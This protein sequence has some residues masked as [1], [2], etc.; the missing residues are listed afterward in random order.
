M[1]ISYGGDSI[2]FADGTNIAS[3]NTGFVNK[4]INGDCRIDQRNAGASVTNATTDT[5]AVDRFRMVG[6]QASKFTGQRSTTAPA[7][8]INSLLITSSSAYTVGSAERFIV[9]QYVEG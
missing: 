2:Q 1:S 3:G 5:F 8:F 4:I 6:S 9:G 7:G